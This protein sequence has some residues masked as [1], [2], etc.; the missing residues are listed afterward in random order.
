MRVSGRRV[1]RV[2]G[3]GMRPKRDSLERSGSCINSSGRLGSRLVVAI[4]DSRWR[5]VD[6][7]LCARARVSRHRFIGTAC[8]IRRANASPFRDLGNSGFEGARESAFS[9][10]AWDFG[11]GRTSIR[12]VT[13]RKTESELFGDLNTSV[14]V[15]R[16]ARFVSVCYS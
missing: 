12:I 8:R 14:A 7:T 11:I 10:I 6:P 9:R 4:L 2:R 5:P 16:K 15:S 1:G 3:W 13:R